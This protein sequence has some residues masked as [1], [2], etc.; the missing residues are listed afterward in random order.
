MKFDSIPTCQQRIGGDH[1]LV[2]GVALQRHRLTGTAQQQAVAG[3]LV[4]NTFDRLLLLL[5]LL[6]LLFLQIVVVLFLRSEAVAAQV[7]SPCVGLKRLAD[8]GHFD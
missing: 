3:R 8:R 5:L 4:W 2:G 6:L 1:V 7:L